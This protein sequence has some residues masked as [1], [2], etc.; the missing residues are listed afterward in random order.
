MKHLPI[1]SKTI[2]LLFSAALLVA[3]SG[4]DTKEQEEAA[5][6]AAAASLKRLAPRSRPRVDACPMHHETVRPGTQQSAYFRWN[7]GS[8]AHRVRVP[9]GVELCPG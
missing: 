9:S 3:C 2:A 1:A 7:F 8:S 4:S 5:A 6:A